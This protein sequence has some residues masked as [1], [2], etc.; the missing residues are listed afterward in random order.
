VHYTPVEIAIVVVG[1]GAGPPK[2]RVDKKE[3]M[4]KVVDSEVRGKD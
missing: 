3:A 1:E 2:A 4:D